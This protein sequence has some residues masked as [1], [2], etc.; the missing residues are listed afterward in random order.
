MKN[1]KVKRIKFPKFEDWWKG[2]SLDTKYETTIGFYAVAI[3]VVSVEISSKK[4]LFQG[5][6]ADLFHWSATNIYAHKV[7]SFSVWLPRDKEQA[8]KWY[9]EAIERLNEEFTSYIKETYLED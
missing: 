6:V 4:F 2:F 9:E 3:S 5:A 7:V 8:K 1:V